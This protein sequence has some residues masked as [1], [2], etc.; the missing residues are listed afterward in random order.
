MA[1]AQAAQVAVGGGSA[2]LVGDLVV[3]VAGA[4]AG[5]A[6][7]KAAAA[8]AGADEPVQRVAGPVARGLRRRAERVTGCQVGGVGERQQRS[9]E[10]VDD[11]DPGQFGQGGAGDP[12]GA[13]QLSERGLLPVGGLQ[14]AGVEALG[15]TVDVNARVG[16]GV[17]GAAGRALV[18]VV[19][20]FAAASSPVA[21]GRGKRPRV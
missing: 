9:G 20:G 2:A 21:A 17:C 16:V 7:G 1:L 14:R 18:G 6:A 19:A 12:P 11:G 5:A 8:V 3:Q 13:E 15:T 10:L 4:G